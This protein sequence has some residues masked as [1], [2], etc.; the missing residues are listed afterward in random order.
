MPSPVDNPGAPPRPTVFISYASEDRA[1]AR[2]LRD[3]LEAAGLDVWYDESD[4]GGGD[5]W[6]QKIRRQIRDCDYF[7]PVISATTNQRREGYFRREWRLA[8]ERTIDMADDV[9]FLLPVTI[10]E[11][12]ETR[13]R[14][15]EKFLAV[16]WMRAP[17]GEP[18]PALM[19]LAQRLAT[20]QHP[21]PLRPER[22]ATRSPLPGS[23][24][25]PAGTPAPPAEGPPT[26]PPFPHLDATHQLGDR[27]KFFAEVLWWFLTAGWVLFKRAPRWARVLLTLWAI[28]M[29]LAKCESGRSGDRHEPSAA[30]AAK[31]AKAQKVLRAA[32]TKAAQAAGDAEK[33]D[34]P[35]DMAHL[36]AKIAH[37]IA[38]GVKEADL[39]GKRLVTVPFSLGVTDANDAKF[40]NAV[41]TSLYGRLAVER[42]G[43]TAILPEPLSA[44]TDEALAGIGH[45][46]AADFTLGAWITR[47]G[48]SA[49]LRVRLIKT[50]GAAVAW[51]EQFPMAGADPAAIAEQIA[52]GVL[53]AVP[54]AQGQ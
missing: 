36:G 23:A 7:M 10:D 30:S 25:P 39:V 32:A 35:T 29:L 15:P 16:Q 24:P 38:A 46:L 19:A 43:E 40:L 27:F 13:A 45:R 28:S 33:G 3:T 49:T 5:A 42:A 48:D 1:T 6:D 54:K 2:R 26:M 51:T 14:V 4:L 9:M 37:D 12:P 20:G 50:E 22:S 53:A 44:T 11:T 18:T 52:T 31:E 17:G 47:N 41:F 34:T 8:S 21:P